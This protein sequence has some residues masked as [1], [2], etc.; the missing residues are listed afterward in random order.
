[1]LSWREWLSS[2]FLP[3]LNYA[4]TCLALSMSMGTKPSLYGIY[5]I[6]KVCSFSQVKS[7]TNKISWLWEEVLEGILIIPGVFFAKSLEFLYACRGCMFFKICFVYFL[8]IGSVLSFR[9]SNAV[10]LRQ[11][12][13]SMPKLLLVIVSEV[14]YLSFWALIINEGNSELG[15]FRP[16]FITFSGAEMWKILNFP[17]VNKIKMLGLDKIRRNFWA[18]QNT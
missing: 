8:I 6:N 16:H 4:G 15:T 11:I 10:G 14:C 1:M 18:I 7:I 9:Q 2:F 17:C 12:S 3:A 5:L 13:L